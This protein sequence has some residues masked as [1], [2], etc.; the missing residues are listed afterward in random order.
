MTTLR[1]DSNS[2]AEFL[3]KTFLGGLTAGILD[4]V[5]AII[6][7]NIVLG[8]APVPIYQTI[9]SGIMG[10]KA[11]AG[12]MATAGLGLAIHFLIAFSAA[13]IYN[14][15][16]MQIQFLRKN[17]ISSGLAFGLG[18]FVFMNYVVIPLSAIPPSPFSLPLF[19]NGV[20]GHA[21]LVGLPIAYLARGGTGQK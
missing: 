10:N 4:A 17:F 18:V 1:S 3:R 14:L 12:G 7:F 11:Y 15:A 5:D 16:A 2:F 9:A 8:V 20:V 13:A 6:A 21:V 19:I